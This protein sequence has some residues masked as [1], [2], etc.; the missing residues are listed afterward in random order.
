MGSACEQ[1]NKHALENSLREAANVG[2]QQLN[3]QYAH[4]H[5]GTIP[6]QT[7]VRNQPNN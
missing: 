2:N 4:N 7:H 5:I 6:L 3:P 1:C